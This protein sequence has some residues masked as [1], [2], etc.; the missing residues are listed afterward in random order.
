[1]GCGAREPDY[2]AARV[3]GASAAIINGREPGESERLATVKAGSCTGVVVAPDVVLTAAHCKNIEV[4]KTHLGEKIRVWDN[5]A[6]PDYAGAGSW[7]NDLRVL[8][9]EDSTAVPPVRV[10]SPQTGPALVSG[11]GVDENGVSGVLRVGD[12][13]IDAVTETVALTAGG[14]VDSCYGDSG[15]PVYQDGL[16]VAIT[17]S[18]RVSGGC[19]TGAA[20]TAV[21]VFADWLDVVTGGAVEFVDVHK[22]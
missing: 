17:S 14:S 16:L 19:G 2:G 20:N 12:T 10:T 7:R 21:D 6:H 13:Y 1:M 4:V 11:Y 3:C 22:C 18:G 15:G 5:I 9:L 8:I